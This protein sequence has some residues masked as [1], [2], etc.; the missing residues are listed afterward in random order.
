MMAILAGSMA[1]SVLLMLLLFPVFGILGIAIAYCAMS[2]VCSVLLW[3]HAR[4]VTG[5]DCSIFSIFR[6][7]VLNHANPFATRA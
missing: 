2:A 6:S 7:G 1:L 5:L 3:L 4:R